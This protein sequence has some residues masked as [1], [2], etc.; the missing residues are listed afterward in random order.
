MVHVYMYPVVGS[1]FTRRP[2]R[3]QNVLGISN[4]PKMPPNYLIKLCV[5]VRLWFVNEFCEYLCRS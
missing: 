3:S 1:I 4:A 5:M 2:L